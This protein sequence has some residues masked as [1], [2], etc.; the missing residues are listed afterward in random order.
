[1]ETS[2]DVAVLR[3]VRGETFFPY[4][5]MEEN[6]DLDL[7]QEALSPRQI[8]RVLL[9][10]A[11]EIGHRLNFENERDL[12]VRLKSR[13]QGHITIAHIVEVARALMDQMVSPYRATL[14]ATTHMSQIDVSH[15]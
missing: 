8:D 4:G 10:V 11:A 7:E 1:M 6:L 3:E 13:L 5:F 15:N 2:I 9:A 12:F 14:N